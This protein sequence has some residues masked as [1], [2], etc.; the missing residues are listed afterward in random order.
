MPGRL[1]LGFAMHLVYVSFA[2]L[3]TAVLDYKIA[4]S[5]PLLSVCSLKL[6][7]CFQY[8][9]QMNFITFVMKAA[10]C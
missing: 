9:S 6:V 4:P 8:L 3:G 2:D 1:M 5:E 7:K 10:A